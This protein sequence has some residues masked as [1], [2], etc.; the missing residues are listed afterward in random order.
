MKRAGEFSAEEL[1]AAVK[2][3]RMASS[4][5][6]AGPTQPPA[7]ATATAASVGVGGA[8]HSAARPHY[9]RNQDDW[10]S[11]NR[12]K[13]IPQYHHHHMQQ[14]QQQSQPQAV[15][16]P[17]SAATSQPSSS[18][19]SGIDMAEITRRINAA[20]AAQQA[21]KGLPV[22]AG[23]VKEEE[24]QVASNTTS[25]LT[26]G[27][28]ADVLSIPVQ[29]P[30]SLRINQDLGEKSAGKGSNKKSGRTGNPLL[31]AAPKPVMPKSSFFD[32]TVVTK[33]FR[34]RMKSSFN[35]VEE[36]HF[37]EMGEQLRK[38]EQRLQDEKNAILEEKGILIPV[39]KLDMDS[40][41]KEESEAQERAE[42]QPEYAGGH[43][44]DDVPSVEWWDQGFLPDDHRKE[45]YNCVTEEGRFEVRPKKISPYVE[46]PIPVDPPCEVK[47]TGAIPLML[48]KKERRKVRTQMRRKREQEKRDMIRMGL[49]EPPPSRI[50]YSNMMRVLQLDHTKDPTKTE[51]A[52]QADYERRKK[53]HEE[54]NAA[55]KL[56]K[57]QKAEKMRKK[58]TKD[59]DV[60]VQVTVYCVKDLRHRLNARKVYLNAK[61]LFLTGACILN[62]EFCLV[63][64]EGSQKSMMKFDKLM[65]HRIDWK[66]RSTHAGFSG[67]S[68][69]DDDRGGINGLSS[70]A[71][72][73]DVDTP[74][75][76]SNEAE[77]V[78]LQV[79]QGVQQKPSFSNFKMQEFPSV[80]VAR[81]YLRDH[82]MEHIW[83][84]AV[85][86]RREKGF[87]QSSL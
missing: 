58:F 5:G 46:H 14:Q 18:A 63:I 64:V 50:R 52:V 81:K 53:Q 42:R 51:K 28:R 55:R 68:D 26:L 20:R 60:Q 22:T 41:K 85:E 79:W 47:M 36:G 54:M 27:S 45:D 38:E 40:L 76:G 78:C 75:N 34:R 66:Q 44:Q 48:T 19:M 33:S 4:A 87:K 71:T 24:A 12:Q 80:D 61:Q 82:S 17:P 1:E 15:Y 56:T 25:S 70:S 84:L 86:L 11:V 77:N 8:S 74:R 9:L 62:D 69:E 67:D 6:F 39:A 57:E 13:L 32:P 49:V 72:G 35:F 29:R 43:W 59:T 65:M 16:Q 10:N 73:M 37:V 7:A 31:D 23:E 3:A 2:R 21:A 30:A 83:D